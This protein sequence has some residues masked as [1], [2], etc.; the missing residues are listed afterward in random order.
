GAG[1]PLLVAEWEGRVVGYASFGDFRPFQGYRHTVENSVYVAPD[2]HRRG[3]GR[4]LME[5]LIHRARAMGKHVMV[6]GIEAENLAS[7]RLHAAA[8]FVEVGRLPQ[9]GRKFGR[10][11]DLVFMQRALDDGEASPPIA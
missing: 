11:L 1:Y 10:W 9:V 7:I 8:G 6:A 4:V 5:A 3:V 2:A